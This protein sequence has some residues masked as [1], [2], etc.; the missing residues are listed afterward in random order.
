MRRVPVDLSGEG[1]MPA[2][3]MSGL[4]KTRRRPAIAAVVALGAISLIGVAAPPAHAGPPT[5]WAGS[6]PGGSVISDGTQS[7][8]QFHYD[9]DPAG[10]PLSWTFSTTA[11]QGAVIRL[12][13]A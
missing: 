4:R 8:P 10:G 11:D 6:G 12:P 9:I 13:Y 2:S 5:V 7:A 1:V 3:V